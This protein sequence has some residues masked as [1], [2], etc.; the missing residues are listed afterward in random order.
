MWAAF[1]MCNAAPGGHEV[2]CA[3]SDLECVA[4]AVAMHDAAV[5]KIGDSGKSDV[6]V[7]AHVQA[8]PGNELNRSHLIEENERADHLALAVRQRATHR[9]AVA[10]ITHS[11]NNDH[12]ESIA[13]SFIAEHRVR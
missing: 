3:G 10:Q 7:R 9:E 13:R 8:L 2:H 6:G 11:W 4:F 1:R 12:V 5:E